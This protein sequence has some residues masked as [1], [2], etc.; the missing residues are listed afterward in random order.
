MKFTAACLILAIAFSC[1]KKESTDIKKINVPDSLISSNNQAVSIEKIPENCYLNVTGK[2]SAAIQLVDNL[3]TFT[4]KMA[5]KN[6]EKDSSYGD[7]GGFKNGDT[8]KLT[9]T[10][11]SE[12]TTSEREVYFLQKDQSLIEGIGNYSSPKTIKFDDKLT[13]KKVDCKQIKNLLK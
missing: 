3:G 7:L 1:T 13:Y 10:F 12:G 9:Y 4:G 5:I 11:A 8:L 2:D 6:S